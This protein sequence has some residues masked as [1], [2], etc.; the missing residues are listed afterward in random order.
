MVIVF[1]CL[2]CNLIILLFPLQFYVLHVK[3]RMSFQMKNQ[4][5][6]INYSVSYALGNSRYYLLLDITDFLFDG[7]R[8]E[9]DML[10]ESVSSTA[11][12]AEDLLN[13]INENKI[14]MDSPVGVEDHFTGLFL[15]LDY[16]IICDSLL[17][18]HYSSF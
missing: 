10:L 17:C 3:V 1:I 11:K 12:R 8:F 7:L 13:S 9:L 6:L 18:E 2:F 15:L 16:R 4:C 5:A 14:N